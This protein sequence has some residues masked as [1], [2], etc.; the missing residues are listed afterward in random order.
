MSNKLLP[1]QLLAEVDDVLRTMPMPDSFQQCGEEHMAWL[2]RASALVYAWD[3]TKAI[4]SFDSH[5]SNM[6]SQQKFVIERGA[7]AA[8]IMLHQLR[9]DVRMKIGT[10]QSKSISTG[11]VFDYFDEVRKVVEISKL[12]LLFIDPYLDAE[13]VSRYLPH[14][15]PG[16]TIRL[17]GREKMSTLIPAVALIRQ[18]NKLKIEV[19]SAQ[20]FHDRYV[21]VDRISCYQSGA[22]FKDGAKKAPTT[23]TQISDAFAAVHATYEDLWTTGVPHP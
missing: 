23:L 10:A 22:S 8:L 7:R 6:S 2:G 5:I 14:V 3:A 17:L 11:D 20:N 13:F 4:V 19:K 16:V 12:D 21:I 18:Q 9:H 1:S 15:A